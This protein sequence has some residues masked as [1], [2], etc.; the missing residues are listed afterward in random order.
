MKKLLLSL[1]IFWIMSVTSAQ[2]INIIPQPASVKQPKNAAKF[3]IT[4]ATQIVLEGSSLEIISG[5]L[6]EYLQQFYH[7]KLKVVKQSSGSNAI[8]LNYEYTSIGWSKHIAPAI[9]FIRHR[10]LFFDAGL[11]SSQIGS[12]PGQSLGIP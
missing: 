12:L 3:S 6:N 2:E 5:Y 7:F 8:I 10:S 1:N 11:A 4:P 9:F